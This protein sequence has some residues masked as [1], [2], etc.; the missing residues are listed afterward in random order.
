MLTS[1]N[2]MITL[3]WALIT[4]HCAGPVSAPRGAETTVRCCAAA[5]NAKT[6]H[7]CCRIYL[8]L[9]NCTDADAAAS[10]ILPAV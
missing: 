9:I 7:V 4:R 3:V 1:L 8:L 5:G 10:L 2:G 6:G